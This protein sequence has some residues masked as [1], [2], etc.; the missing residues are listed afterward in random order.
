MPFVVPDGGPPSERYVVR[1]DFVGDPW[2]GE[3]PDNLQGMWQVVRADN[4]VDDP[5]ISRIAGWHGYSGAPW[6]LSKHEV[7]TVVD[8]CLKTSG[9]STI[10]AYSRSPVTELTK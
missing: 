8:R 4:A 3:V 10:C 7:E 9:R 5:D 2:R 1:R 6:P